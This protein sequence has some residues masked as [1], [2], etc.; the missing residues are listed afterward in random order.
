MTDRVLFSLVCQYQHFWE[1][2][3][4][5]EADVGVRT[6][7]KCVVSPAAGVREQLS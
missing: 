6:V 1:R 7:F 2:A 4:G 5:L 3:G